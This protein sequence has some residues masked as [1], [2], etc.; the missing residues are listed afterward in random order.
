VPLRRYGPAALAAATAA[1]RAGTDVQTALQQAG[2][3]YE[4]VVGLSQYFQS[5]SVPELE[6]LSQ[7][8]EPEMS[9]SKRARTSSSGS[10]VTSAYARRR[11]PPVAPSVKKYVKGCM[12]RLLEV[13]TLTETQAGSVT[14]TTAGAVRTLCLP[15]ITQGDGDSN[16]EGNIIHVKLVRIRYFATDT[17]ASFLRLIIFVDH[18]QNGTTPGVTQV[19]NQASYL[20]LYNP[21][22][23]VGNGGARY[24][25]LYD[26]T[27]VITPELAAT[28]SLTGLVTKQIRLNMPVTYLGNAGTDADIGTNGLFLLAISSSNTCTYQ[29]APQIIYTDN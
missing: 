28:A 1:W 12:D 23:V 20:S 14:P 6:L 11:S 16:R 2:Y 27:H 24:K 4:V 15:S 26:A 21:E 9:S 7:S 10:A 22:R 29:Y 18:Q 19:L 8:T 25:I 17:V 13:K 3:A 5:A